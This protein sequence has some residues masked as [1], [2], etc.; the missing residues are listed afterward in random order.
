MKSEWKIKKSSTTLSVRQARRESQSK[1]GEL[2]NLSCLTLRK[3]LRTICIV[4][5]K[6]STSQLTGM[7]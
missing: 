6:V 4:V 1:S 2:A 5:S 3:S 7:C